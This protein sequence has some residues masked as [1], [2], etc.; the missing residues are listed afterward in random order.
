MTL[1][2]TETAEQLEVTVDMCTIIVRRLKRR[3]R[4]GEGRLLALRVKSQ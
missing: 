4:A 3:E 1:S 2:E